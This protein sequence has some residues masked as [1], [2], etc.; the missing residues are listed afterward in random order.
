MGVALFSGVSNIL[1]LTGSFFMLE[2]YDRVLPS[3]SIPTLIG[4]CILA[5]LLFVGQALLDLIRGRIL[6]RVGYSIDAALTHRLFESVVQL[7][8]R[9]GK[10][11]D[12]LQPLRDMDIVR[13]FLSGIGP[14]TLFDLPWIPLYLGLI[15]AFH[16]LLGVVTLIGALILVAL[17]VATEFMI[18]KPTVDAT[19]HGN[20]RNR[21]AE[22][23][24]RNAEVLAAMGFTERLRVLWAKSHAQTL[25][26]Q[27]QASDIAGGLGAIAKV[28]R[29]V[30]QSAVLAV[31]AY[32]VIR[33]EAT[34][35]IIIAGSIL[36]GR[37]LAPV[38]MAIAQ[39]RSFV[40]ARQSWARLQKLLLAIPVP[41]E[42]M[43]LPAPEKTVSLEAVS[44][45]PPGDKRILV[46]DVTLLLKAGQGLGIVGP[47]GSGKSSLVRAVVGAWLPARGRV[48]LDGA[49]LDQWSPVSL[50]Q[51]I[52]YLPQDVELFAGTVAENIARFDPDAKPETVVQAA[53]AADVHD[54]IVALA[55]GYDTQVGDDGTSLSGG[56]RQRIGLARA[57]YGNPF[58]VV[59]DEP[60]ASL[61]VAGEQAVRQAIQGIRERRGIAIVISHR[62]HVLDS[63]D[64]LLAM[65]GGR[66]LD[67]GLKENVLKK[68]GRHAP[69]ANVV[70]QLK[71]VPYSTNL[72][73]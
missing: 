14:V 53:K 13:G 2:V 67:F 49:S 35:G 62:P 22:A 57:L 18:R 20:V 28:L 19:N 56:Q 73:P 32:L 54:L 43:Q 29:M 24:K 30:L 45:S 37:A 66:A 26:A 48:K 21:L 59:L 58:L 17:T 16:P 70:E 71:V 12:G 47:S 44:V 1:M 15:F 68:L 65:K 40:A 39:W 63:V 50:G 41:P 6:L 60:D 51:H 3:R 9:V 4:L 7:P 69:A 72:K 52:G 25:A 27:G 23:S 5:S 61:D 11:I 8:L 34:G 33:Q 36:A 31:G 46:Q 64:H 10:R 55:K 42:P 38:D